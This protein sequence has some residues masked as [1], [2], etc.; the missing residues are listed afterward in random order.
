MV[1][2]K[3]TKSVGERVKKI[4]WR[5]GDKHGRC[6]RRNWACQWG[7]WREERGGSE[8]KRC[9]MKRAHAEMINVPD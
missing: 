5:A 9:E 1:F 6:A 3:V 8:Q 2:R 7:R 4:E